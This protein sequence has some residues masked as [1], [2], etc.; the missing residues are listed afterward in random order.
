MKSLSNR[1]F[2]VTIV[3][4]IGL[5]AVGKVSAQGSPPPT[6]GQPPSKMQCVQGLNLTKEQKAQL[7]L[8][9]KEPEPVKRQQK[10][11]QSRFSALCAL[12]L[13]KSCPYPIKRL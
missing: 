4:L 3:G 10:L 11:E 6:G 8:I 13:H 12:I 5:S 2:A 1:L 7:A 9:K